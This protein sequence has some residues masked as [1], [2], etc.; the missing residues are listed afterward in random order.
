MRKAKKEFDWLDDPFDDKKAAQD[1]LQA[2]TPGGLKLAVV[3][4]V[5]IIIVVLIFTLGSAL[6]I[7]GDR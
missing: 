1:R 4:I 5:L 2:K 6:A 7:L 3:L